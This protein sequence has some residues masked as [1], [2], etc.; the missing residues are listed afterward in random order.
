MLSNHYL[1]ACG[2]R[3][4]W[5]DVLMSALELRGSTQTQF[6]SWYSEEAW[7]K[8]AKC[9]S[10]PVLLLHRSWR[11]MWH[12]QKGLG[13]IR[14]LEMETSTRLSRCALPELGSAHLHK[15]VLVQTVSNRGTGMG[16]T[17]T[18][19]QNTFSRSLAV[20]FGSWDTKYSFTGL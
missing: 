16:E 3:L 6:K 9:L 15:A 8:R 14:C 18:E 13:N 17:S 5:K 2:I 7:D 19:I 12:C 4:K 11:L 10:D 1:K 20:C